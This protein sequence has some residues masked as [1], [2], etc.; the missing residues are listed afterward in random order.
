MSIEVTGID[1]LE[2]LIQQAGA[3]AQKG[4]ADQMKKEAIAI[5]DLA[6]KFA[7]L[8]H[9]NLEAAINVSENS[10]GRNEYGQFMRKSYTVFVDM[11]HSAPNNKTVGDYAYIM[12]EHLAPYGPYNL[13]PLSQ[14]KQSRQSEMVGG[15]YMDRAVDQV[16]KGMIGRLSDVARSYL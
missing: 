1:T 11:T 16:M 8:D 10:G 7:P 3:R 14:A 9:G 12:H 13:G 5:R 4:V 15:L 6:R 2:Y